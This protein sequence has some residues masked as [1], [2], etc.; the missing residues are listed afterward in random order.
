MIMKHGMNKEFLFGKLFT[1]EFNKTL[2]ANTKTGNFDLITLITIYLFSS[3]IF[4]SLFKLNDEIM[5]VFIVALTSSFIFIL[6][7]FFYQ[8]TTS[9]LVYFCFE[10]SLII[11]CKFI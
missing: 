9:I 10:M 8:T 7:F 6:S 3:T 11:I 4:T 5:C 1:L 2:M